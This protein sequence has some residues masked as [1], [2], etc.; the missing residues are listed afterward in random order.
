MVMRRWALALGLLLAPVPSGACG[1]ELVLAVDVSRSVSNA[2]YDQQVGGLAAAF[3]H[4]DFIEAIGY[5]HGGVAVTLMQWSGPESQVQTIPWQL[6]STPEQIARLANAIEED[7]RKF[8]AAY[9][10]IGD[11]LVHARELTKQ[12][13]WT[14]ERRVIDLSGDGISNRGTPPR[15][16]ADALAAEGVTINA[17]VIDGAQPDPVSYYADHVIA[18]DGAFMIIARDFDD[19][20]RA[21]REKL[22]RELAPAF[23]Q[24]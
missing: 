16:I 15:G 22:G 1:I 19:Y 13:P 17:V 24:R 8:F 4:P 14:C 23:A 3:R 9:T 12:N 5:V 10:A 11:A 7:R 18:G 21:I 20:A 2:E 6:I